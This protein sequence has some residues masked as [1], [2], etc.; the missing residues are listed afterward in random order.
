L[1][2]ANADSSPAVPADKPTLK[3]RKVKALV[4]GDSGPQD[5]PL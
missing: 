3:A 1:S 2:A 5:A 4:T